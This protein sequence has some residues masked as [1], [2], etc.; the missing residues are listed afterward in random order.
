[1]NKPR[2]PRIAFVAALLAAAP[3][4]AYQQGTYFVVA[5]APADAPSAAFAGRDRLAVDLFAPAPKPA[6]A[7]EAALP[8][9][10][11]GANDT[12]EAPAGEPFSLG[13]SE[14]KK[15]SSEELF[16]LDPYAMPE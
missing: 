13:D 7:D 11:Y 15:K 12:A 8:G 2:S 10:D 4:M 5:L 3:T 14:E 1:M 6:D 16:D 9:V